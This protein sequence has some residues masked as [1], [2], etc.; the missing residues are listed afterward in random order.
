[1]QSAAVIPAYNEAKTIRKVVEQTRNFVNKV[2]VVDDGSND[3]TA[4]E[5]EGGGAEVISYR[6]NRGKAHAIRLG[7][8]ECRDCD[9]VVVLDADLQHLPEEIPLLLKCIDD[10]SD[11]CIG[12]RALKVNNMPS[13]RRLSN[14]V[15]STLIGRLIGKRITDPQSGFR[16]IRG[17]KLGL[18]ELRAERYAIEHVM[19]LEAARKGFKICEVPVSCRYAGEESDIKMVRDTVRV[20]YY[21]SR[22]LVARR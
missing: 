9:V 6:R 13:S 15:A 11:L 21:I 17:E 16:A 7:F 5:A 1:M 8:R 19:I 3:A 14:W 10:G 4:I 22:F 2:V 18:L 20:I 12:S